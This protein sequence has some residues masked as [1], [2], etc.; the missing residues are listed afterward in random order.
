[1][2]GFRVV[3]ELEHDPYLAQ[4][5]AEARFFAEQIAELVED[6]KTNF[7]ATSESADQNHS[8]VSVTVRRNPADW[9]D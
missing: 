2:S 3:L 1:V 9:N 4:T 5:H 6:A 8:V 7:S